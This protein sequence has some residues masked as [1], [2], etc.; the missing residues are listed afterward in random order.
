MSELTGVEAGQDVAANPSLSKRFIIE[1]KGSLNGVPLDHDRALGFVQEYLEGVREKIR[2]FPSREEGLNMS[3]VHAYREKEGI[4]LK[5]IRFLSPEDYAQALELV[6]HEQRDNEFGQYLDAYDMI[7]V[8]RDPDTE[9]LNGGPEFTESAAVHEIGHSDEERPI[10]VVV[11]AKSK[12][13][14][15]DE[16]HLDIATEPS[17]FFADNGDDD[18]IG[19]FQ[20]EGYAELKRGRY[21]VEELGKPDG[22]AG[23]F[24][25]EKSLRID[26]H[27]AW[28]R[29]D[30]QAIVKGTPPPAIAAVLFE[31]IGDHDSEFIPLLHRARHSEAARIEFA[32]RM[33]AISPDLYEESRKIDIRIEEGYREAGALYKKVNQILKARRESQVI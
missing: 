22:F 23:R 16:V 19:T 18:E 12:E 3:R 25:P 4:P 10:H 5:E 6:D 33:N 13:F 31:L 14:G 15:K 2:Q 30:T 11:T 1:V 24:S 8:V 28:K 20:E 27:A 17:G 29:D 32:Q 7:L 26:K 21:I 9:A